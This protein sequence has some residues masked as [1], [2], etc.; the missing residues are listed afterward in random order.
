MK[1]KK[2]ARKEQQ[3]ERLKNEIL[4]AAVEVFKECGYEKATI[5]KIA[6]KAEVADGSIYNYFENKRDILLCLFKT[7]SDRTTDGLTNLFA[8]ADDINKLISTGIVYQFH[9]D[10]TLPVLTLL[11][12]ET[13]IDPEVQKIFS[14]LKRTLRESAIERTK[15]FAKAGNIRK[16]DHVIFAIL[17]NAITVGITTLIESGDEELAKIPINDFA[18]EITDILVNGLTPL[19]AKG[20]VKFKEEIQKN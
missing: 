4:E 8:D 10:S 3:T 1:A 12:H 7:L 5:K 9:Q 11:L 13:G 16:I 17:M 15:K 6:E 18:N 2:I 19:K 20:S 14:E